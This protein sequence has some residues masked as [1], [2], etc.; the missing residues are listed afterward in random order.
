VS[1]APGATIG[2]L[3]GGQLGRMTAMAA[4]AL[5]YD[6]VVLDPDPGCS[7]APVASRVIVAPFDDVD[8]AAELGRACD[9][10]TL[11]IERIGIDAA[12]AAAAHAPLR[13]SFGV[14]EIIQDRARQKRWLGDSGFA[15]A[16]YADAADAAEAVRAVGT[17]GAP[18][19]VKRTYGG[20]DGRGQV[21]VDRV[22]AAAETIALLGPGPLVVEREIALV[23]E[24]SVL[25]ARSPSGQRCA[26]PAAQ[27]WHRDGILT[28]SVLPAAY[29]PEVCEAAQAMALAIAEALGLEGILVVEF[30]W[31]GAELLVNELAPRP[32]NT[33][34]TS[35]LACATSQ[36]EQ[37]IRAVCDL[38][39]GDAA[40]RVPTALVNLL[41]DEWLAGGPPRFDAALAVP[42]AQL[43]LYG[44]APR[45]LRKVGHL[46]ATADT[47]EAAVARALEAFEAF[48]WRPPAEI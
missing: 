47:S 24:L 31:T 23:A 29:D 48:H 15:V 18:C 30:F 44:K 1:I 7:A 28:H 22:E 16:A 4:R 40:A 21:R 6:V 39:L 35:E 42:G 9:V 20:Y 3:G 11:E 2:V 27:N 43:R 26:Y 19:R 34:H 32:H 33:Y 45:P 14:L 5:G 25:V 8:A 41:G 46:M 37:L 13:P 36:F 38:P 17:L 12:R 10:V